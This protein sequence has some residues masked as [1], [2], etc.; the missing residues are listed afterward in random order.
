MCLSGALIGAGDE[1]RGVQI[2]VVVGFM[3]C[4]R[5]GEFVGAV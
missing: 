2:I 1:K 5:I 3:R 4:V